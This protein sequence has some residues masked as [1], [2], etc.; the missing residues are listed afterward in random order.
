VLGGQPRAAV[1]YLKPVITQ[2]ANCL[3]GALFA[4]FSQR[5]FAGSK[6]LDRG[7]NDLHQQKAHIL[8]TWAKNVSNLLHQIRSPA[9]ELAALA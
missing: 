3:P 6:R 5:T 7:N 9:C 1:P 2:T 4:G 8:S